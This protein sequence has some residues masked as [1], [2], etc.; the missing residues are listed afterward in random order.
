MRSSRARRM[1]AAPDRPEITPVWSPVRCASQSPTP[2]LASYLF[3]SRSASTN[4]IPPS[5]ITPSTSRRMRSMRRARGRSGV[6]Q[7]MGGLR[8]SEELR[9]PEVVDVQ[10]PLDPAPPVD[11]DQGGYLACFEDAEG[12]R[13]QDL[14]PDRDGRARHRFV[15]L[16][17]QDVLA[18]PEHPAQ[19]AVGEDARQDA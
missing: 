4:Q 11:H 14:P 9:A 8:G 12:L 15:D 18:A 7:R 10:D 13:R 6:R 16:Q 1:I 2:S 3:P 17:G 19:V 5:V